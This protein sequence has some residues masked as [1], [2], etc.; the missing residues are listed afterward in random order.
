LAISVE[1][2]TNLKDLATSKGGCL[3]GVANPKVGFEKALPGHRPLDI[4][5][6]CRSVIVIGV[7]TGTEMD[8]FL[9]PATHGNDAFDRLS[10]LFLDSILLSGKQFLEDKGYESRVVEGMS[11]Q[12]KSI[13]VLGYKVCAYEAG[14]GVY[15]RFGVIVTERDGPS[16]N[17]GVLL[18]DAELASTGRLGGFEPCKDCTVCAALCPAEA[19]DKAKPPPTGHDRGKCVSFVMGLRDYYSEVGG[20]RGHCGVCFEK[21]PVGR[22]VI[23]KTGFVEAR[24]SGIVH[25]TKEKA[26]EIAETI[27]SSPKYLKEQAENRYGVSSF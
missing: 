11:D 1:L 27:V 18:T 4:M 22:E 20:Y 7:A 13:P 9:K 24:Q 5:P 14:L 19:I 6:S 12:R 25:E 17:W 16:V 15:G 2:T 8:R 21:C 3:F 10:Y 23:V 26:A